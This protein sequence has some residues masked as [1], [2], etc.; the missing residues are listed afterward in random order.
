MWENHSFQKHCL[1]RVTT[2]SFCGTQR[3]RGNCWLVGVTSVFFVRDQLQ[4]TPSRSMWRTFPLLHRL[5]RPSRVRHVGPHKSHRMRTWCTDSG[6]VAQLYPTG[7][8][9]AS[10]RSSSITLS[11][12]YPEPRGLLGP[13]NPL[14]AN[15]SQP[16]TGQSHSVC[17]GLHRGVLS[18]HLRFA[19]PATI[20]TAMRPETVCTSSLFSFIFSLLFH[21]VSFLFS[22]LSS[23]PSST[24]SPSIV[25]VVV[26]VWRPQIH[27]AVHPPLA[28]AP[29]LHH[30]AFPYLQHRLLC[31][32]PLDHCFQFM[33]ECVPNSSIWLLP[34][35]LSN[36]W[37]VPAT[38]SLVTLQDP[39]PAST[40]D[41]GTNTKP[42]FLST[43]S[44]ITSLLFKEIPNFPI[45]WTF[46]RPN[47]PW[48]TKRTTLYTWLIN[49]LHMFR[50]FC[51]LLRETPG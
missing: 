24:S 12:C 28:P 51:W 16:V 29:H 41:G 23:G 49:G 4:I 3:N 22:S 26:C 34:N 14:Q 21:L 31:G 39:F 15:A 17:I 36:W 2:S 27:H 48:F 32:K 7:N 37:P 46:T 18:T 43:V 5:T 20:K 44:P 19:S 10:R 1:A 47:W 42:C 11:T 30:L 9:R 25:C 13:G 40:T 6:V 38:P 45:A 8:S 35:H 50:A 33:S